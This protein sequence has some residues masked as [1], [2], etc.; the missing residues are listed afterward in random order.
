M[1]SPSALIRESVVVRATSTNHGV[2]CNKTRTT[3]PY[4]PALPSQP[5]ASLYAG[6]VVRS[7]RGGEYG[8]GPQT[9]KC[10]VTPPPVPEAS[11]DA[12]ADLRPRRRA[13]SPGVVVLGLS[14]RGEGGGLLYA[15]A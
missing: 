10:V 15:R 13:L 1:R 4:S 6:G 12:P 7:T 14:T 3:A 9:D 8:L 5:V 11:L 2:R